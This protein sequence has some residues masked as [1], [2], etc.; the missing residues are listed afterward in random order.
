MKKKNK[1]IIILI[2]ILIG[3]SSIAFAIAL[4]SKEGRKVIDSQMKMK[5]NQSGVNDV[6]NTIIDVNYQTITS[7]EKNDD[8]NGYIIIDAEDGYIKNNIDNLL[9][10]AEKNKV[11]LTFIE[12]NEILNKDNPYYEKIEE[13]GHTI[14][15]KHLDLKQIFNS[16]NI[17]IVENK[18]EINNKEHIDNKQDTVFYIELNDNVKDIKEINSNIT[19]GIDKLKENGYRFKAFI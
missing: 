1:V 16:N 17:K 6:V 2:S 7:L 3:I 10:L 13:S 9:N 11:K 4:N 14:L 15:P 18:Q 19:N 8:S 5:S 12:N